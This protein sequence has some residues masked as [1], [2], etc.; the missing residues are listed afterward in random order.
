VDPGLIP[1]PV[2]LK[3][4][5]VYENPRMQLLPVTSQAF[6]MLPSQLRVPPGQFVHVPVAQVWISAVH[7]DVEPHVPFAEHSCV[8]LP[9]H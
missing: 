1:G 3:L 8:A 4:L 7:G 5:G 2:G 6:A 9:E